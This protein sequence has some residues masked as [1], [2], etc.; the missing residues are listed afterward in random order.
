MPE[1]KSGSI[2]KKNN[3]MF[4]AKKSTNSPAVGKTIKDLDLNYGE[5]INDSH[6]ASVMHPTQASYESA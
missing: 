5:K 2:M 4:G 3:Y 1:E 6:I